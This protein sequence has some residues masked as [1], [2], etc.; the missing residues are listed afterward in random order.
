MLS[1]SCLCGDISYTISGEVLT[2]AIC[3]CLTC[4]KLSGSSYTTCFLI[5]DPDSGPEAAAQFKLQSK[6]DAPL[7]ESSTI[8]ETGVKI[9]F[10]GCAKCPSIIYKTAPE[11]FPGVIIMFAGSLDGDEGDLRAKGGAEGLG[12]PEA[13][14]WVKYRLPWVKELDGAKQCQQFE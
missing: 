5:R 3:H 12:S 11:G 7:R 14:L 4:R 13:E 1:G 8:H 2:K 9:N 6:T 10:F